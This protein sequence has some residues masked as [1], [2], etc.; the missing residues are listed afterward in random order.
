MTRNKRTVHQT[1]EVLSAS[2]NDETVAI[3]LN[4]LL[5]VDANPA[6]TDEE[7]GIGE[8]L[9]DRLSQLRPSAVQLAQNL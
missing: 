2:L 9:F 6:L 8:I 5:G 7:V 1:A 3:L 4:E